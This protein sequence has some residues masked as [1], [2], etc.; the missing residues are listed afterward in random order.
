MYQISLWDDA[1]VG[2]FFYG[3]SSNTGPIFLSPG[4]VFYTN[5]VKYDII[6]DYETD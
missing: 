3:L 6:N 2:N 5:G 1:K 4:G